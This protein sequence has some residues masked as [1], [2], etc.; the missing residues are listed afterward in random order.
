M[1]VYRK[2]SVSEK[3][4]DLIFYLASRG[5]LHYAHEDASYLVDTPCWDVSK[6]YWKLFNKRGIWRKRWYVG[7]IT[8]ARMLAYGT[9]TPPFFSEDPY[10]AHHIC[11]NSWCINPDHIILVSRR[12]HARIHG[13]GHR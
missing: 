4:R 9:S 3:N 13:R 7:R 12:E 11:G 8:L 5:M 10:D 1:Q 2:Q 6:V